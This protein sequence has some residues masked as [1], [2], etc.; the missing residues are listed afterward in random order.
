MC[1]PAGGHFRESAHPSTDIQHQFS[2]QVLGTKSRTLAKCN[3][4]PVTVGIIH[5]RARV[6][7]PLKSET[8]S[9]S[10]RIYKADYAVQRGILL[11]TAGTYESIRTLI[12]PVVTLQAA[13]DSQE[14]VSDSRP[15]P[16]RVFHH[17]HTSLCLRYSFRPAGTC[18]HLGGRW[19]CDKPHRCSPP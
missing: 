7:L 2:R 4:S 9:I 19:R 1:A 3:L 11:S 8:A 15:A 12:Q 13:K 14:V 10:L 5:L 6:D 16:A 18:P 17:F